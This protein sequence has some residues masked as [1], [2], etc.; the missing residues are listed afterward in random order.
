MRVYSLTLVPALFA[1]WIEMW[2]P[3]FLLLLP[4]LSHHEDSSPLET[5]A[6][7]KPFPYVAFGPGILSQQ[8]KSKQY[9]LLSHYVSDPTVIKCLS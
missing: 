8:Q 5:P 9:N 6:N 7:I 4:C 2:L 1:Y 3:N